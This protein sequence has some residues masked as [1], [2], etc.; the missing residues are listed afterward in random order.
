MAF[1]FGNGLSALGTA[2]EKTAGAYTLE[3]QKA[4]LEQQKIVLA[5]QLAGARE[6]KGRQFTTSE[7]VATQGFTA[8]ENVENRKS[9]LGIAQLQ[10]DAAVKAAGIHAGGTVA[11]AQIGA[12]AHSGDVMAQIKAQ[13]E[14]E[15][16]R[17]AQNKPLVDAEVLAKNIASTNVKQLQEARDEKVAARSSNDPIKIK[18]ADQKIY[19]L[20]Y[21]SQTAVQ[22]A[23]VYQAQAK[24]AENAYT[25]AQTRL[26]QAQ[27][28]TMATMPENKALID[29]LAKQVEQLRSEYSAAVRT[30]QDAVKN[31]PS[32]NPPVAG[33]DAPG[34]IQYDS[35]GN[36]V[37]GAPAAAPPAAKPGLIDTPMSP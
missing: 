31:L 5:D 18:Q 15:D 32:Y 8:G 29:S 24:L 36:R 19:D 2:V 26:V 12:T 10:A 21:S 17:L 7:R 22:Q 37:T 14:A 25:S 13:A 30:A 27:N 23:S 34:V 11:A 1:D 6:E 9:A 28:S 3:T 20:E 33:T 35:K 16:K 4:E